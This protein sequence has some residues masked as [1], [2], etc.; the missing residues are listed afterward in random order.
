MI[1]SILNGGLF[2]V[3]MGSKVSTTI[4]N[5]LTSSQLLPLVSSLN[6]KLQDYFKLFETSPE[7]ADGNQPQALI[8]TIYVL[9][10]TSFVLPF[11]PFA[12]FQAS[13]TVITQLEVEGVALH[14][15][16]IKPGL[17]LCHAIAKRSDAPL[18]LQL[19]GTMVQRLVSSIIDTCPWIPLQ[20]LPELV[21]NYVVV[22]TAHIHDNYPG[23]IAEFGLESVSSPFSFSYIERYLDFI[24]VPPL[25]SRLMCERYYSTH[26][27]FRRY[28][29]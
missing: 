15:L 1:S 20:E 12:S 8:E 3:Q 4:S 16:V 19:C 11:V 24:P 29:R 2:G 25:A 7:I 10:L 27:H 6:S 5:F 21:A 26:E 18:E 28:T 14:E 9:R 23:Q 13:S 22:Q 17:Q